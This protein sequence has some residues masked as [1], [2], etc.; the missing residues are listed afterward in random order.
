MGKLA[1]QRIGSYLHQTGKFFSIAALTYFT[2]VPPALSQVKDKIPRTITV[3]G[4]GIEFIAT[5][6]SQVDVGVDIQE[7]TAEN[8]QKRAA[9]LSSTVVKYLKSNNVE[10]LQTTGI[11][12][13][14]VYKYTNNIQQITGYRAVN[15]VSF[16]VPTNKMGNILDGVVKAGATRINSINFIA[17]DE[18]IANAQKKALQAATQDAQSQAQAV[19]TSLGLTRKDVVNITINSRNNYPV[20]VSNRSVA[21][22]PTKETSTPVI[23][24]EQQVE[25]SVTLMISY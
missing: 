5:T 1:L 22:M 16:R 9:V 7:K 2:F 18:A 23:G 8:A 12:L 17:K 19:L 4:R 25:A 21:A 10:K 6:R 20:P 24:G 13:S 14:P 11:S 3:T 15:R